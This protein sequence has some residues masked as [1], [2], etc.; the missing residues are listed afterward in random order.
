MIQKYFEGEIQKIVSGI[1]RRKREP[2][3][4][5]FGLQTLFWIKAKIAFLSKLFL[6]GIEVSSRNSAS[7]F[8]STLTGLLWNSQ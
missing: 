5:K 2:V 7:E 1:R 4:G 6:T 3:R 8:F